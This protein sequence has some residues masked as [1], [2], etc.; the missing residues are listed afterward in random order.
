MLAHGHL[1]AIDQRPT[2]RFSDR[3]RPEPRWFMP[4][5]F[6]QLRSVEPVQRVRGGRDQNRGEFGR[7]PS[8]LG[9]GPNLRRLGACDHRNRIAAD[10]RKRDEDES[11]DTAHLLKLSRRATGCPKEFSECRPRPSAIELKMQGFCCKALSLPID[12]PEVR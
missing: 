3:Q 4:H 12:P 11:C 2:V 5:P 1:H 8:G 7:R 6:E 10:T 9:Q